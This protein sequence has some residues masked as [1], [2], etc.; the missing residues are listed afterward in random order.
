MDIFRIRESVTA[1]L[2]FP[3]AVSPSTKQYW[4]DKIIN[5]A[6]KMRIMRMVSLWITASFVNIDTT[7]SAAKILTM[8]ENVVKIKARIKI[9]RSLLL[10]RS[11]FLAP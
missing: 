2:A 3:K 1:Y 4:K 5:P 7:G 8:V 11:V 6:I 10:T 9:E